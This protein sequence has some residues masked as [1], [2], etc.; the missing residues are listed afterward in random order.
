[1][2]RLTRP[3]SLL[4]CFLLVLCGFS[5]CGNAPAP[6]S[7]GETSED[8][9]LNITL[10]ST[11]A[12]ILAGDYNVAESGTEYLFVAVEVENTSDSDLTIHSSDFSFST[13]QGQA[14]QTTILTYQYEGL[15]PLSVS[16]TIPSGRKN[17]FYLTAM[18][19]ET[20]ENVTLTYKDGRTFQI[21]HTPFLTDSE[22]SNDQASTPAA[23]HVGDTIKNS[24]F[25]CTL[26]SVLQTDY[27]PYLSTMYY[28]PDAGKHFVI[29]FFH[30][31][32]ASA[33]PIQFNYLS[34]FD[35]YVDDYTCKFTSFFSDI[36]GLSDLG[37][38]K[39]SDINSGKSIAGYCALE[40]SDQW[41]VIEIVTKWGTFEIAPSDV[42]IE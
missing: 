33:K 38:Y 24:T 7:V 9:K 18:I 2:N 20:C 5:G 4:I 36:D 16:T 8:S 42:T 31:Q 10:Q 29:L 35:A 27:I 14:E 37:D 3:V 34:H 25:E 39:Y 28:S 26:D 32:N 6:V 13:D 40:V 21:S 30:I 22:T 11:D 12:S 17:S 15:S 41:Q 19:P 23:F 1:M